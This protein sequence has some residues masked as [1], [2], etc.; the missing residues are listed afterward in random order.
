MKRNSTILYVFSF[1]ALILSCQAY[2]QNYPDYPKQTIDVSK[3]DQFIDEVYADVTEYKTAD[4]KAKELTKLNRI[5][6]HQVPVGE[7]PECPLLSSAIKKNKYNP[8]INYSLANFDPQNFNPLI[9]FLKYSDNNSNYYRVDG[10]AYIIE[11][12]PLH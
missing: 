11:I 10:H 12:K 6:I 9:Y 7:Y 8:T 5:V 2:A 4:H 1:F 3:I